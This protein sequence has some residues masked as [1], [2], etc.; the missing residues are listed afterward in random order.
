[1]DTSCY[2]Q[3]NKY[4]RKCERLRA[5]EDVEREQ[6]EEDEINAKGCLINH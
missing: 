5:S 4:I 3:R 1:M 2:A 6:R